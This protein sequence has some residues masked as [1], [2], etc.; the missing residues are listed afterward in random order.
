MSKR[1][2]Y[3]WQDPSWPNFKWNS[4]S[5]M[6]LLEEVGFQQGE[7]IGKFRSYG[8]TQSKELWLE[9]LIQE[10]TSTSKIEGIEIDANSFRSSLLKKLGMKQIYKSHKRTE[11]GLAEL[12]ISCTQYYQERL[13]L[14]MLHGWHRE[15]FPTGVS[16]LMRITAGKFR[17]EG[18]Q[19]VSG[20]TRERVHFEAP[21]AKSVLKEMKSC[22]AWINRNDAIPGNVKAGIAHLY[23]ITVH[24]YEDGNGRL[25]R[26]LSDFLL[27]KNERIG[28]RSYSFSKAIYKKRNEYYEILEKTQKG[29]MDI[30]MW[31]QW[32]LETLKEAVLDSHIMIKAVQDKACYWTYAYKMGVSERQEKVLRKMTDMHPQEFLGGMTPKKYASINSCL[33]EAASREIRDL[34]KK[35]LLKKD[36]SS[37]GGRSVRYI[38]NVDLS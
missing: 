26:C 37:G 22:I 10:A 9:N 18:I 4:D 12:L 5:L 28:M 11:D 35:N 25:A 30:T 8:P 20:I 24:P 3:I 36:P 17:P 32:F 33:P 27:A 29:G 38:L 16:G 21:S 14:K 19:V 6:A 2:R 15:L 1:L 34:L 31:L 23:F 7:L 13:S